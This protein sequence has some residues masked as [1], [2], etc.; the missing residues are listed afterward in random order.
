MSC[1]LC[2]RVVNDGEVFTFQYSASDPDIKPYDGQQAT[3]VRPLDDTEADLHE[4]GAMYRV[5]FPDGFEYDV[6]EDELLDAAS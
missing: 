3:V 4:T 6:F 2:D 5:R 1:P